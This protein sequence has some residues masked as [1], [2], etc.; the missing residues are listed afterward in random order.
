MEK[1]ISKKW[2]NN[3][4]EHITQINSRTNN[5]QYINEQN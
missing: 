5:I 4:S 2:N 3:I 1:N